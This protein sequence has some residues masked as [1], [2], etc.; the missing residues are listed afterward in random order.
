MLKH[1]P[2]QTMRWR[3][4]GQSG[5]CRP[6]LHAWSVLGYVSV[7]ILLHIASTLRLTNMEME[8]GPLEDHVPLHTGGELHFHVSELEW[9]V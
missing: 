3:K 4:L 1:L 6:C 9:P 7:N 2:A 5:T 8:G